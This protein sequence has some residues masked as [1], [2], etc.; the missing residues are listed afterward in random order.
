M[1]KVAQM[2]KG[3]AKGCMSTTTKTMGRAMGN[4]QTKAEKKKK[5]RENDKI[6]QQITPIRKTKTQGKIANKDT[7]S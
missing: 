7:S 3:I 2:A 1:T 5:G 4:I 6:R